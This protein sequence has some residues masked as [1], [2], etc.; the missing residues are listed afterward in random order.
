MRSKTLWEDQK[1]LFAVGALKSSA[2][3][4]FAEKAKTTEVVI[5]CGCTEEFSAKSL[6]RKSKNNRSC[7][8]FLVLLNDVMRNTQLLTHRSFYDTLSMWSSL[9]RSGL[10]PLCVNGSADR[11]FN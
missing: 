10:F 6:C 1:S 11:L 2:L 7:Y 9:Y 4:A 8:S 5:V 3:I